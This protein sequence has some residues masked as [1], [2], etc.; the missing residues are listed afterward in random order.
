MLPAVPTT[1]PP[2]EAPVWR[3]AGWYRARDEKAGCRRSATCQA[4]SL[5]FECASRSMTE[6][7]APSIGR[8]RPA[9]K[10]CIISVRGGARQVRS[11]IEKGLRR[12]S[13]FSTRIV[14]RTTPQTACRAWSRVHANV[15]APPGT[16]WRVHGLRCSS[17]LK[18]DTKSRELDGAD[19]HVLDR[20]ALTL[21]QPAS[22]ESA[23]SI[24]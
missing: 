12:S 19:Q 15:A 13:C 1:L 9:L 7:T 6:L 22:D 5:H 23:V 14:T 11:T 20:E 8:A 2:G 21:P 10:V 24:P 18:L 4:A 3:S 17:C 16:E